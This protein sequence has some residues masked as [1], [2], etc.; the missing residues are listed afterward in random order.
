MSRKDYKL[1]T[2]NLKTQPLSAN[3][4]KLRE[5]EKKGDSILML[6]KKQSKKYESKHKKKWTKRQKRQWWLSLSAEEKA[7]FINKKVAKKSQGRRL[8]MLQIIKENNLE[9][10][11]KKCIHGLGGSCT[12]RPVGGCAYYYNAK[13]DEHGPAYAA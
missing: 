11:C 10:D 3:D 12:N 4:K 8:K 6:D 1:T 9:F 2:S 5:L 13:T 7:A